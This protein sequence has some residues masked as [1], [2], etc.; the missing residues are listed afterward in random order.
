MVLPSLPRLQIALA[1]LLCQGPAV[2]WKQPRGVL[3]TLDPGPNR[4]TLTR[5]RSAVDQSNER[6]LPVVGFEGVYEV[7]DLG[8]VRGVPRANSRGDR[9]PGKVLRGVRHSAGYMKVHLRREGRSHN[10][11][12]HRLVLTA[13]VGPCPLGMEAL[14]RDGDPANGSLANLH[15]GT[16]A[17]NV[18]DIIRH[19]RHL[20][21]LVT[22]CKFGHRLAEPNIAAAAARRGHRGCLACSRARAYVYQVDGL[23]FKQISDRYYAEIMGA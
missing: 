3:P 22:H 12:V 6:W 4:N 11:Y 14:H 20:P 9:L 19:G 13:F 10:L 16:H 23:D 7:S 18:S 21:T 17:E 15:W 2:E 8:R 1:D 5:R